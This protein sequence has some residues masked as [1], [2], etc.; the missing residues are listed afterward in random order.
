MAAENN[1]IAR[2]ITQNLSQNSLLS[3]IDQL[4]CGKSIYAPSKELKCEENTLFRIKQN[5]KRKSS[6]N[7]W[8]LVLRKTVNS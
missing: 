8:I 7:L 3:I 1:K 4:K 5:I 2:W 6:E